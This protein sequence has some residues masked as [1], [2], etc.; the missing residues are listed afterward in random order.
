MNIKCKG[1]NPCTGCGVCA[2]VCP[3]KAI[4]IRYNESGFY[5]PVIEQTACTDCGICIN[6]CYK[7][8]PRPPKFT[9]FFFEKKIY[10]CWSNDSHTRL[11]STSGGVGHELLKWGIENKYTICGV[12][13]DAET[14]TCKH[15]LTNS[16]NDLEQIKT[17]KYLQSYT[18]E[19]FSTF[20][21]DKKYIVVGTPCQI[22]GLK[23][24]A[25]LKKR[26]DDFIF[27]DFFCHGTPTV[28]LWQKYKDYIKSSYKMDDFKEVIFR[29]KEQTSWHFYAT[30]IVDIN[31]KIYKV[32]NSQ[33]EDLFFKFFLSNICL[34][35]SCYNCM[36][37]LDNC[38]SDIRIADFWGTKY[39]DNKDGVS[40]VTVNTLSGKNIF[41]LIYPSLVAEECS[42]SDLQDSQSYRYF[43]NNL[44]K[45]KKVITLLQGKKT[46]DI[47]FN[48]TLKTTILSRIKK[49]MVQ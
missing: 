25:E 3:Q 11:T 12:V 33:S 44:R 7:Y 20:K 17:S 4:K 10:A 22:Y 1:I 32:N 2:I 27:V 31:G 9:N 47:I 30:K 8:L 14:D 16:L 15:I 28:L 39:K 40:L 34:N 36:H 21:K 46:L 26:T 41:N 6:V 18:Y 23:Q 43:Y 42:F 19:A 38:A 24:W 29:S 35:E 5:S 49:L 48:K 37:R 13:F 45:R